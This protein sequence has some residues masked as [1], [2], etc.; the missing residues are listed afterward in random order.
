MFGKW[1]QRGF[2]VAVATGT[3]A[4]FGQ[5]CTVD[6]ESQLFIR[7]VLAPQAP[8][9]QVQADTSSVSQGL[10]IIDTAIST[11]YKAWLL[12]GNQLVTRGSQDQVRT[13]TSRISFKSAEVH[14]TQASSGAELG[15]YSVPVTGFVDPSSGTEPG[16]G[17]VLLPLI[18]RS[19]LEKL[20]FSDPSQL[21]RIIAT[22]K[23]EGRTLGGS[24]IKS[25]E[26]QFVVQAC[27]ACLVSYGA[28]DISTEVSATDSTKYKYGQPNCYGAGDPDQK[29]ETVD[30]PCFGGQDAAIPCQLCRSESC[31]N[32]FP[33]N[34]AIPK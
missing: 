9:C 29:N 16:Y 32:P 26:F 23:L 10:G 24:D 34:N 15:A 1:I 12:V 18:D 14:V 17:V 31:R 5:G 30:L 20:S 13:E 21:T 8:D 28:K 25:N 6:Q 3:T 27:R 33:D 22:V 4:L 2:L 7:A 19:S 11:E